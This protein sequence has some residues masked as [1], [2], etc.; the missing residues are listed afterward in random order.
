MKNIAIAEISE[1]NNVD[2]MNVVIEM[3]LYISFI[4]TIAN[5]KLINL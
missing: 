5:R 3:K 1:S 4:K 2:T